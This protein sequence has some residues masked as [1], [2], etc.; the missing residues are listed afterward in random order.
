MFCGGN[1]SALLCLRKKTSPISDE[2]L[3]NIKVKVKKASAIK[4][5]DQRKS[6][7]LIDSYNAQ[8]KGIYDL[9]KSIKKKK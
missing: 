8:K 5:E 1:Q 3:Q 2:D 4:L 6:S 7:V 9:R